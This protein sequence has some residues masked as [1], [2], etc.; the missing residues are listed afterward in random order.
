MKRNDLL[1][2]PDALVLFSGGKD[3]FLTTL[4]LLHE[5][6]RVTLLTCD[7]GSEMCIRNVEHSVIR[8]KK[9]WGDC[10]S[11]AGIC[12]TI[13]KVRILSQNWVQMT[14]SELSSR[15]PNLT[16]AQVQCLHCQTAMWLSAIATCKARNIQVIGT[17]Y[18]KCDVFCT[19]TDWYNEAI[20]QLC[21][22]YN[23]QVKRPRWENTSDYG[24]DRE[25]LFYGYYFSV[26]EPKCI[27]GVW[28]NNLSSNVYED[29]RCYFSEVLLPI[30]KE[31]VD[32]AAAVYSHIR[33]DDE[34]LSGIS[35]D[36]EYCRKIIASI[37]VSE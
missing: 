2:L 24:R 12:T 4:N 19:G 18:K 17:G 28:P 6:Y 5:G 29:M 13:A 14:V 22:D 30:C 34:D 27:L 25:M 15:W 23:I 7:N 32:D 26:F 33:F 16:Q 11:F 37:A 35:H 8:L 20:D 10:V 31:Q 21:A 9:E 3:S 36:E 1:S